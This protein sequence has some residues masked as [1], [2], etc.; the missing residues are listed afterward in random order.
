[1]LRSLRGV[2]AADIMTTPPVMVKLTDTARTALE[3]LR[4][5]RVNRLPV[6]DAAGILCG[7]VTRSDLLHATLI[8]AED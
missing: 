6:V 4:G 8:Q 5:A 7:I 2:R 3:L 1:M